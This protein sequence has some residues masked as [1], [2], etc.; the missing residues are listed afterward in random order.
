MKTLL[1]ALLLFVSTYTLSQTCGTDIFRSLNNS[2][3]DLKNENRVNEII[4][5]HNLNHSSLHN[6]V[7]VIP[8]A[9]HIIHQN[10]P[11]NISDS[12]VIA[13]INNLNLRYANAS[14]FFDSTGHDIQIQFCL[15]TVD[16]AGN[17]T[18]GI[19]RNVSP[20]TDL[21]S[22]A[23][24][25]DEGMKNL[26]RW[27]PHL[28]LNIWV[29][30]SINGPLLGAAGYSNYPGNAG[31]ATD[32]IVIWYTYLNN[33]ALAH[34]AGHYLGLYHTFN[35]KCRNLNCALEGDF[36]CDTPP[37][38]TKDN[39]VCTLN[40]CSSEMDD[41][42]GFNPFTQDVNDLPNYMDYTSCPLSFSNG[43][44]LR[45][46]TA[47]SQ[48]RT[49]LLQSNGCGQNPGGAV[50]TASFMFVDTCPF[51]YFID[52]DPNSLGASWDF[53]SDG[54]IDNYGKYVYSPFTTYG[55]Y[56]ITMIACGYGGLDT[57]VQT[58]TIYGKPSQMYPIV[59]GWTGMG[60]S[61][62]N[63]GQLSFCQGATVSVYGEPGFS[64]YQ[65]SNG[66]TTQNVTFNPVGSFTLSL[67]ATDSLGHVW[68]SCFPLTATQ[69]SAT[70]PP[71]LSFIPFDDAY[72]YDDFG[73]SITVHADLSPL[74]YT[75]FWTTLGGV[76]INVPDSMNYQTAITVFSTYFSVSQTDSNGCYS[77][78][79]IT[80]NLDYN[81]P[82]FN[83][84][85]SGD[86][87]TAQLPGAYFHWYHDGVLVPNADSNTIVMNHTGCYT[88]LGW[89]GVQEGCGRFADDTVC[90]I[91]PSVTDVNDENFLIYPNPVRDKLMIKLKDT[92]QR[93]FAVFDIT[94]IL[95][96]QR[97]IDRTTELE[98][99]SFPAGAYLIKSGERVWK[100]MKAE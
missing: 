41:T 75:V 56:T 8:V 80:L 25:G 74:H 63:P 97:V 67:S 77:A 60:G 37:D 99:S 33:P 11:E 69:A 36:V 30:R 15:A 23:T 79:T 58:L 31:E 83:I 71:V 90:V 57:T 35:G 2:E 5:T 42:S 29:V 44:A 46:N 96:Y 4:Y 61:V 1:S 7:S 91:L 22:S 87:L 16:P 84:L 54:L 89:F 86:T 78:A 81:T 55:T 47:L 34:E 9:V 24:T 19:T 27:D 64:S 82:P 6:S 20:Y 49:T 62:Y 68:V 76:Q 88:V 53:N 50:P 94:G 93:E 92:R 13:A 21:F 72:C 39:L 32:G 14:P 17:P 95:I 18:N 3:K 66:T 43:Q 38:T 48:I 73:D 100:V 52:T 51:A 65:W 40:S 12:A 26:I 45:M 70:I 28:Y 98:F 10:G 85:Q 59:N